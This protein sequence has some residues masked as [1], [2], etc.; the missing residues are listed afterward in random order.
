MTMN[1]YI[2]MTASAH[3]PASWKWYGTYR[4]VA[5]VETDLPAPSVPAMISERARGV[6]RIVD[7]WER[8]NVGKTERDAY[9]KALFEAGKLAAKLTAELAA[10]D[11]ERRMRRRVKDHARRMLARLSNKEIDNDRTGP[12][13]D[14]GALPQGGSPA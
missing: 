13:E 14:N 4:R 3:V 12:E 8:L 1:R 5:V 9:S 7:T 2:V 6:V 10:A 11:V